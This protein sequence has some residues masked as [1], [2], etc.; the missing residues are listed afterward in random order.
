MM[1]TLHIDLKFVSLIS[2]RLRNWLFKGNG[3]SSFSHH[4]ERQD[5]HKRR[6]YFLPFK[7]RII[8]KCHNCGASTSLGKFIKEIDPTLY[9][10][11]R[12]EVFKET[13]T[14]TSYTTY[15]SPVIEQRQSDS[16]IGL[17]GLISYS[18]LAKSNPARLYLEKRKLPEDKI[19]L[20]Y[21]APKFFKWASNYDDTF[22]K[23]KEDHPR[24]I[25]PVYNAEKS[26]IGFSCR[27]FG[28]EQPKYI[29]LRVDKTAE[30]IYGLD[31]VDMSKPIIAV[32]G[33][34]DSLF[35]DNSIAVGS[36]N[37]NL[38]FI[39]NNDNV[40]IV[41]DNDFRRNI[42]V[43]NQLKSAVKKGKTI[44]L[45][46]SHFKKDINDIIKKDNV[47]KEELMDYI[48]SHRKSGAEALLEI[49]LEKKC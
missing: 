4:C 23:F 7:G 9:S 21:L 15:K 35:L 38:D 31:T 5:S 20:F 47:T 43:C 37:Y 29:Q 11:Y 17:D 32:E 13:T 22:K 19:N 48:L 46:P 6:A 25:L 45:L 41:P 34:I 12:L 14:S 3:K 49:A 16:I 30:Y 36:A 8:M 42:Q 26:I 1:N 2:N 24:L 33:Q 39:M 10:E 44:S 28:K 18:K 40:I 27:A